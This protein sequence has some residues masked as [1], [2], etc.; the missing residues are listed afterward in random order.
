MYWSFY[1]DATPNGYSVTEGGSSGSPLINNNRHIIGQLYGIDEGDCDA[2][3]RDISVYGKFSFSWNGDPTSNSRKRRLRDWLD[4]ANINPQTWNGIGVINTSSSISGPTV[5][6]DQ[7][8]YTIQN[9][10]SGVSVQWSTSNGNLQ[11]ISGQG[12]RTAVF[13]KNG[14]GEC[15]IRA[16]IASSTIT[17]RVWAGVPS[18]VDY[19]E[20]MREGSQFKPNSTY[21]FSIENDP[22]SDNVTWTVGGGQIESGQ[23][24]N[25]IFVKT[26]DAGRFFIW[27]RKRNRCGT[28]GAQ[29]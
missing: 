4:P 5:V 7:E 3:D 12:A 23:G 6:C 11:L 19:I 16:R 29:I 9:L 20:G 22:N 18:R 17:Y 13:R 24:T 14:S 27:A 15:M 10:P 8:T 21:V 28:G 25:Q 26:S 1:W 2:P